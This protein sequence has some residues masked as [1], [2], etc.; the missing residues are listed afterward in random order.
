MQRNHK[1]IDR[2][3]ESYVPSGTYEGQFVLFRAENRPAGITSDSR[4]GWD[5]FTNSPIEI[6][7]VKGSHGALTVYPFAAD[8]AAKF[9][10]FITEKNTNFSQIPRFATAA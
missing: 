3:L 1:A 9:K 2:A 4:L 6:I 7:D 10:P 8:L 5:K